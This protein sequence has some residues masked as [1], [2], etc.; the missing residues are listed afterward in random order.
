MNEIVVL[1][2]VGVTAGIISGL[3]GVGGGIV[4]VPALVLILGVTQHEAQGTSTA[5]LLFPI[6]ILAA[7]N[8]SQQGY[9]NWKFVGIMTLTFIIG[10]FIGSKVAISLDQRMLKRVFGLLMFISAIKMFYDS[11]K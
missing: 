2:I 1:L 9:I 7:Y 6:G 4:M 5:T 3:A 10:S 8:Y 11:F